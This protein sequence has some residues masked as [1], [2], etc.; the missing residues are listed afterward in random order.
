M[1]QFADA[2]AAVQ[3]LAGRIV[4]EAQRDKVALSDVERG[5]LYFSETG[6]APPEAVAANQR[7][8]EECS[9]KGYEA[10]VARLIRRA[11]ARAAKE[12]KAE[13]RAWT[14]AI[15]TLDGEDYYLLTMLDRAGAP[16][17][18]VGDLPHPWLA[19]LAIVALGGLFVVYLP[20]RLG[21]RWDDWG[22]ILWAAALCGSCVWYF[23]ST[24]GGEKAKRAL[25]AV[26]RF[27][28]G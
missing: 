23:L 16:M 28:L 11:L 25:D 14:E 20:H 17:R 15:R 6:W 22:G 1:S 26:S 27:F 2:R 7:F 12:D 19:G 21:M 5:M 4:A 9:P 18:R 8:G 3:F 13:V 24:Y 10:K